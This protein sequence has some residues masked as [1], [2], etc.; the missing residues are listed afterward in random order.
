MSTKT[1]APSFQTGDAS[2]TPARFIIV[3][4]DKGGVGKSFLAQALADFLLE[5]KEGLAIIDADT[6]N[7]DVLRMFEKYVPCCLAN[8]RSENGWMDVMDFVIRHPGET[9]I[10][11]TPQGIGEY[12]RADMTSFS[13]FLAAEDVPVQ[14]ELWW[15][16]NVGHDSV[17]LLAKANE[18]YG[19]FFERIRVVCNLHF[20]N[21]DKTDQGPFMLW[22]ES[23]LRTRIEK[24]NGMTLFF[25]GLHVRV[26]KKL[27]APLHTMPFGHAEDASTGEAI[28]LEASERWKLTQ[29]RNDIKK[30]MSPAFATEPAPP[31]ALV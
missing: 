5:R 10:M 4:G 8:V 31:V 3:G 13:E 11:N 1:K 12:M 18:A 23:P 15:T 20:A 21:G 19:Q 26:V 2:T 27:F 24:N 9:I 28:G 7:P 30:L 25:P 29:W 16:M 14:M 6:A 17:N 22:H